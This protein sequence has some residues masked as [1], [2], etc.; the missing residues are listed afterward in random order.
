MSMPTVSGTMHKRILKQLM[1]KQS[2]HEFL[3][4]EIPP[5]VGY[6]RMDLLP[7]S[8]GYRLIL[9]VK[10]PQRL[11]GRRMRKRFQELIGRIKEEFDIQLVKVDVRDLEKIGE[12]PELNA[13]LLAEEIARAIGRGISVR[14]IAYSVMNRVMR[15]NALG[16][17]IRIR[18]KLQRRRARRLRF[19]MG[20]LLSSGEPA[21]KFVDIGKASVLVK[22]GVIGVQVK[23]VKGEAAEKLPDR[24]R[25]KPIEE[26]SGDIE[27]FK[28][29]IDD[30]AKE[31]LEQLGVTGE[32]TVIEEAIS[33]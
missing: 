33:E 4:E 18:G 20:I 29:M 5:A 11:I 15:K 3:K 27:K 12:D 6:A 22:T 26:I 28:K 13:Q 2:L 16:V 8:M 24:I 17:E 14:R 32:A 9:Y 10:S 7:T 30:K 25:V 23:I 1:L 21:E 19:A 31:I